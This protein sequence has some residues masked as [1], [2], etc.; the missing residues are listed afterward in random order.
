MTDNT[1]TTHT[2]KTLRDNRRSAAPSK[3]PS[4]TGEMTQMV[5]I[6]I[7]AGLLT[8]VLTFPMTMPG[9]TFAEP[10]TDIDTADFGPAFERPDCHPPGLEA[11]GLSAWIAGVPPHRATRCLPGHGRFPATRGKTAPGAKRLDP[12]IPSGASTGAPS[13]PT[14][15][16]EP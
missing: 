7:A 5:L 16:M 9:R 10:L 11:T 14:T 2:Q 12:T 4:G 8:G 1:S 15:R 6:M 3:L 13:T